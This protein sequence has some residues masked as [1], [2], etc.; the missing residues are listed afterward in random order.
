MD[1]TKHSVLALDDS[2]L[3]RKTMSLILESLGYNAS[4]CAKG[5]DAIAL[6]ITAQESGRPYLAVIL[7]LGIFDG[8]GG[9]KA[10]EQILLVDPNAR[11]IA[12]SGYTDDPVMVDHKSFGFY[13]SL[14]KPFRASDMAEA[15]ATLHTM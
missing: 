7:D 8:M 5:E 1:C 9:G 11:L 6:Y 2:A 10:A 3:I 12:C 4:T 14:P 15:L 13:L